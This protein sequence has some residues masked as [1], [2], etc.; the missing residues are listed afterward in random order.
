M[1][2]RPT[3]LDAGRMVLA[4]SNRGKLRE[5]NEI[6]APLHISA[7]PQSEFDIEPVDETGLTFVENALLKA[8]AAAERADLPALADDSG[9]IVDALDGQPG[10]HSARYAGP[11]ADDEANNAKLLRALDGLPPERRSAAFF[12]CMV[13]L[14]HPLDPAP[15]IVTG[16]WRGEIL[17][18]PRGDGGFGYD[19]LF[20]DRQ[21]GA[22]AAELPLGEKNRVSH[23][24]Q[25]L[26]ALLDKLS[27]DRQ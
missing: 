27:A 25:A 19:P 26:K 13:L 1:P 9:L 16:S 22:T 12:C 5:I 10:I 2:E 17:A 8:R 4:S 14:R 20:Y 21:L 18:S 3:G 11:E 15:L 7:R 23:R 24:G 6:L